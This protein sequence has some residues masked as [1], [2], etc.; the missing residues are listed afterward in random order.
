M[1]PVVLPVLV[2][3][4]AP[5]VR[6][7]VPLTLPVLVAVESV[8]AF[9]SAS[10]DAFALVRSSPLPDLPPATSPRESA[11]PPPLSFLEGVANMVIPEPSLPLLLPFASPLTLESVDTPAE[12]LPSPLLLPFA[13][14]LTFESVETPAEA[15]PLPL[16]PASAPPPLEDDFSEVVAAAE[17]D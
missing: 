17:L 11:L 10:L 13:S 5:P 4:L 8:L 6:L 1:L 7:V 12:A 16:A 9:M 2:P 14:P 15:L 3:V